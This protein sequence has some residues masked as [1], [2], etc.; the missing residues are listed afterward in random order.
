[1]LRDALAGFLQEPFS[2]FGCA[3]APS[4][5]FVRPRLR[6]KRAMRAGRGLLWEE[7]GGEDERTSVAAQAETVSDRPNQMTHTPPVSVVLLVIMAMQPWV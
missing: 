5:S 7:N 4:S 3:S 1:M 2:F 6:L